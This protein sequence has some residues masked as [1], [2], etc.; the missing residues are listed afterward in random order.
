MTDQKLSIDAPAPDFDLTSTEDV[1]LMLRDEVPRNAVLL[2][3]FSEIDD[4]ARD[5]LSALSALVPDWGAKNLRVMALAPVKVA[6]LK[7]L[8]QELQLAFPLLE[9]DRDFCARYGVG[10]EASARRLV[11]VDRHGKVGW[12]TDSWSDISSLSGEITAN[13]AVKETTLV[14]YPGKVV[15]RLVNWWVN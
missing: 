10:E 5:D 15:N 1:L 14:N 9:D 11:L 12:E 13:G 2:Y 6:Q 7:Q 3:V 8:Q 4:A